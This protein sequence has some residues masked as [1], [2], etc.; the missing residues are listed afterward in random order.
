M[1]ARSCGYHGNRRAGVSS[2]RRAVLRIPDLSTF[3]PR[4]CVSV[5][6]SKVGELR[7]H[8]A[9]FK[10]AENFLLTWTFRWDDL[11]H[12]HSLICWFSADSLMTRSSVGSRAACSHWAH[13]RRVKPRRPETETTDRWQ[14]E[15]SN[16]KQSLDSDELS[17]TKIEQL[18]FII[19]IL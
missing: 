4:H 1:C 16:E 7:S 8:D 5:R 10:A 17:K 9:L 12:F 2:V 18:S 19:I 11:S 15:T 6:R 13:K 14:D 3:V